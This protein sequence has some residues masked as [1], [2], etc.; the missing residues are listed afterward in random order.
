MHNKKMV[1]KRYNFTLTKETYQKL[2][3]LAERHFRS[4][5]S[6]I[7]IMIK[8]FYDDKKDIRHAIIKDMI[9]KD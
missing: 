4:K 5:S 7:E 8:E 9:E 6:M 3:E 1:K 2:E